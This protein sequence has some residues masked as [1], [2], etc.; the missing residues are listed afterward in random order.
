[1]SKKSKKVEKETRRLMEGMADLVKRKG[2]KYKF[3]TGKKKQ[4]R[5]IKRSCVHWIIRKGKDSPTVSPDPNNPMNWKCNICQVSFPVKPL[6]RLEDYYEITEKFLS[7]VNQIQFWGVKM[8]GD[9]DDTKLF[10]RLKSD[11]PRF[12]K[13]QRNILKQVNKRQEW[14]NRRKNSD[15]LAQFDS[16]AGFNYK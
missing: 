1:M 5:K 10:L 15:S 16:F 13:A 7:Y 6:D 2:D 4:I 3:K 11:I 14:D 8:G 9:A 12:V